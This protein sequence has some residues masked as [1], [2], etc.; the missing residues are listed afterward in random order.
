[1]QLTTIKLGGVLGKKYGKTF[2]MAARTP[3]EAIRMLAATF[4]TFMEDLGSTT[5]E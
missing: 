1:M 5:T 3:S 4:K 2:K